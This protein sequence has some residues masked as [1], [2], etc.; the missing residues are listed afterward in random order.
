MQAT[1]RARKPSRFRLPKGTTHWRF[2][3]RG[4]LAKG[5]YSAYVQGTD[6]AGNVARK[7]PKTAIRAFRV[8]CAQCG[9]AMRRAMAAA[10]AGRSSA[11]LRRRPPVVRT[12][13]TAERR[14]GR[15]RRCWTSATSR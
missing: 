15:P 11:K 9:P 7:L 13:S 4:H 6:V 3:F 2:A 8:R 1:Y 12:R 14:S 5:R 10:V